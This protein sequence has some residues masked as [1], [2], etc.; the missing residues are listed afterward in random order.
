MVKTK[1]NPSKTPDVDRILGNLVDGFIGSPK[2][3][4][5]KTSKGENTEDLERRVEKNIKKKRCNV[6]ISAKSL[7]ATSSDDVPAPLPSQMMN[8]NYMEQS[9]DESEEEYDE[10]Q[11]NQKKK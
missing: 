3:T 6:G 8:P 1:K 5:K 9:I 10:P 2:K 7:Y 4:K 11:E